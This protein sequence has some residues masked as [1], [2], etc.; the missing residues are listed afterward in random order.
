MINM[1]HLTFSDST[2]HIRHFTNCIT[3]FG[4][5]RI[6]TFSGRGAQWCDC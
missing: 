2:A 3:N 5:L 4:D 6:L 1:K